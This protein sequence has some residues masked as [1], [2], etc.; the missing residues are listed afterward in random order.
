MGKSQ[1]KKA[2]GIQWKPLLVLVE[3][4]KENPDNPKIITEG[5]KA[6]LRKSVGKFGLAGTIICN[7][8]LTIIDGHSRKEWL[9][10]E[11]IKEVYVS[12][13][14]RLLSPDEYREFNQVHDMI[15]AGELDKSLLDIDILNEWDNIDF[16]PDGFDELE[17]GN[18]VPEAKYPL[19][20]RFDERYDALIIICKNEVDKTY[21]REVLGMQKSSCYKTAHVGESHIITSDKFIK[22]WKS[23]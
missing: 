14:D 4:L 13:P 17:P 10:A 7:T 11:G 8:D 3:Q 1:P 12:V 18:A 23:K 5:G 15:H 20:P 2:H 21:I 6:K 16:E 22:Q 9:M 19:V